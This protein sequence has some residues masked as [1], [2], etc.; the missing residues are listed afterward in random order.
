[1]DFSKIKNIFNKKENISTNQDK[2]SS[3]YEIVY[4][5]LSEENKEKIKSTI[6]K[7][8]INNYESIVKYGKNFCKRS[9]INLEVLQKVVSE[10]RTLVDELNYI[11]ANIPKYKLIRK[12]YPDFGKVLVP[13]NESK[14]ISNENYD[15]YISFLLFRITLLNNEAKVLQKKIKEIESLARM[16]YI[17]FDEFS[18]KDNN[19]TN[20]R[21][22]EEKNRL[23]NQLQI[24]RSN[25]YSATLASSSIQYESL[26]EKANSIVLK[27]YNGVSSKIV[28][29]IQDSNYFKHEFVSVIQTF[30]LLPEFSDEDFTTDLRKRISRYVDNDHGFDELMECLSGYRYFMDKII[31]KHRQDYSIFMDKLRV[32]I[33]KYENA[34]TRDWNKSELETEIS[35]FDTI[36]NN[37][38]SVSKYYLNDSII[39]DIKNALLKL[40]YFGYSLSDGKISDRKTFTYE[41]QK[42]Y[43]DKVSYDLLKKIS[44]SNLTPLQAWE[45]RHKHKA[46]I[47]SLSANKDL[48]FLYD[49]LKDDFSRLPLGLIDESELISHEDGSVGCY[50]KL[51]EFIDQLGKCK[52]PNGLVHRDDSKEVWI[53]KEKAIS[54]VDLYHIMKCLNID[55]DYFYRILRKKKFQSNRTGLGVEL[56]DLLFKTWFNRYEKVHDDRIMIIPKSL[57]ICGNEEEFYLRKYPTKQMINA[58]WVSSSKQLENIRNYY[59]KYKSIKYVFV[60]AD[61]FEEFRK[62]DY[63]ARIANIHSPMGFDFVF[64]ENAMERE[65][66]AA[67]LINGLGDVKVVVIGE[68]K[69][70]DLP[71]ILNEKPGIRKI[72]GLSYAKR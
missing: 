10:Q 35:D 67:M 28:L 31:Y 15:E 26:V 27:N 33:K 62:I 45:K 72:K 24:V 43:F 47:K 44:E 50:L 29:S 32:T 37:F 58:L 13:E 68:T 46:I 41:E 25:L 42:N 11:I 40:C 18:K 6:E 9:Q 8:D 22:I 1:M 69:L 21:V 2:T 3:S 61:V 65:R 51:D 71:D 16:D 14:V 57:T 19:S 56:K 4:D 70:Y 17:A 49:I 59:D 55:L 39:N 38:L 48:H 60:H 63:F 52:N 7:L 34:N 66:R 30:A 5:E 36:I 64:E 53:R 54:I 20:A 23:K 12:R